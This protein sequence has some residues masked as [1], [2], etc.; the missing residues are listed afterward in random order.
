[1]GDTGVDA[2][3]V[4]VLSLVG[5]RTVGDHHDSSM[6]GVT[7]PEPKQQTVCSAEEVELSEHFEAQNITSEPLISHTMSFTI[8]KLGFSYILL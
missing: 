6:Y 5:A 2:A 4:T 7:Q 8:F 1:M 3:S